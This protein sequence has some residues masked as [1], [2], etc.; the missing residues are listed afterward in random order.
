[1][2]WIT[3]L[4]TGVHGRITRQTF[5]ICFAVLITIEE[6]SGW[7][8]H[9]IQGDKLAA[10]VGLVLNYPEFAVAVKRANDRNLPVAA[11]A[12]FF[13][14]DTMAGFLGLLNSNG[15]LAPDA[16]ASI[17]LAYL[18]LALLVVLVADL[19]FRRGTVGPNPY[20]PDP[21]GGKV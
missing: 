13:I 16:P 19:G 18:W 12:A 11:V 10:I 14:V 1:M 6:A 17:V 4:F 7:L 3:Y 9:Q 20:G 21:L 2:S 15:T 5:W 8:A